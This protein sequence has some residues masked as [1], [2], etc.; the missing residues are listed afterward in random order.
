MK[1]LMRP[2]LDNRFG[3]GGVGTVIDKLYQ[4]LPKLGV[5]M[6]EPGAPYDVEVV[7][8][9]S[10]SFTAP[11]GANVAMLHG[12][13]WTAE[14]QM[15]ST[16]HNTNTRIIHSIR[17]SRAVTVPSAWVAA[18][19]QRDFNINPFIVPHGV[20]VEEWDGGANEGYILWAK[21][22]DQHVCTP[23]HVQEMAKRLP[24]YQF[25]STFG[26]PADNMRV[27][28][29]AFSREDMRRAML[30]CSVWLHTTPETWGIATIEAMAAGKPVVAFDQGYVDYIRHGENGFLA[31]LEDYD[32]MAYGIN[33][34]MNNY[35]V[36][37]RNARLTA[38]QYTWEKACEALIEAMEHAERMTKERG[39]TFVIPARNKAKTLGGAVESALNQDT[40]EPIQVIIV[41][42]ASTDNTREVGENYAKKE[43]VRYIRNDD[44]WGVANAR[45]IG[46]AAATGD[47]IVTLDADD[48]VAPS[49]VSTCIRRLRHDPTLGVVYTG[50]GTVREDGAVVKSKWPVPFDF[51]KQLNGSNCVPTCAMFRKEMWRR[52]GGWR[53]RYNR[54]HFLGFGSEDAAFWL[55]GAVLGWGIDQVTED[56]LFL[57]RTGG[58]TSKNYNELPW[59]T[60]NRWDKYLPAPAPRKAHDDPLI[61]IYEPARVAV[62]IPVGPGHEALVQD[63]I[64]SV[65]AQSYYRTE[66]IVVWD[67]PQQIPKWYKSG[68]P[69]VKWIRRDVLSEPLG[70]GA[71]R[72]R[73]ARAASR[74]ASFYIFLDADDML[75]PEYIRETVRAWNSSGKIPYTDYIGTQILDENTSPDSVVGK[76]H[77]DDLS[78]MV[79]VRAVLNDFD[80]ERAVTQP[81]DPPYVWCPVTSLIPK[82][83]YDEIGGF[84]EDLETWEDWDF[85]IRLAKAGHEYRRIPEPLLHYRLW[86][87]KRREF[88]R[89]K[90]SDLSLFDRVGR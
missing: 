76:I 1:V 20:D 82:L 16:Y 48:E 8:A 42:D 32:A 52:V 51:Q 54:Y 73:G 84:N 36:L 14:M 2:G 26:E 28:G 79:Y 9:G 41:D 46:V 33:W 47:F 72:N 38:E 53:S 61:R 69:F 21:N 74:Y 88:G 87:G 10:V 49:F 22:T 17:N 78:R 11:R 40:S 3:V 63:A 70:A 18:T 12:M 81:T 71:A 19:I 25:M 50:L 59:N 80:A 37:S 55:H 31:P 34:V 68:Y 89:Q 6:V 29:G 66:I 15:G 75:Y 65:V 62:V 35:D 43:N 64:D 13:Y 90:F 5:T 86:A 24:Q 83:W 85:H 58:G 27:N 39:V 60:F 57:Y 23:Q 44:R 67:T 7:H 45:N 30:G 4:H 56:P 77:F